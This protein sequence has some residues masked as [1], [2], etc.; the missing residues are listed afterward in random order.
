LVEC[1]TL[2]TRLE[3]RTEQIKYPAGLSTPIAGEEA[4]GVL[5]L[6]ADDPEQRM[7]SEEQLAFLLD[8]LKNSTAKWKVVN[9]QVIISGWNA[10]G[11]PRL[12][13]PAADA[14][15]FLRDGGNALNPDS[16]DGY[17]FQRN[18]IL[19]FLKNEGIDN[20]IFLTGDVHSSW[21]FDMTPDPFNPATDYNPLTGDGAVGV[22]FVCPGISSPPLGDTFQGDPFASVIEQA[23]LAGN[24]QMKMT[25]V[26]NNGY[27]ILDITPETAQ[28]DWYF[29]DS[30]TE[31]SDNE[32]WFEGWLTNDGDNH[33][34]QAA[35][36][37]GA[38]A[39][40]PASPPT[41]APESEPAPAAETAAQALPATGG[42]AVLAAALIAG[43]SAL[44]AR[45]VR[46]GDEGNG[47]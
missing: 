2:D 37:S 45:G 33:L 13:G 40:A 14:P 24:P 18:Q 31:V 11:L 7:I 28:A 27:L 32:S 6:F 46:S 12:P 20:V 41:S 10:G 16:W 22:E 39:S 44:R 15:Q 47:P 38:S 3:G 23:F 35:A 17:N 26:R 43:A 25:N 9:Q 29:V 5:G 19:D 34:T 42:G 8:R 36:E 4:L 30:V 1:I 21:A